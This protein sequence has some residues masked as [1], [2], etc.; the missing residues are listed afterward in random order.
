M[1]KLIASDID[2]T[3]LPKGQKTID[4]DTLRVVSEILDNGIE[5][6]AISGRPRN[7]VMNLFAPVA[8]RIW[9][10]SDNGTILWE[11][12]RTNKIAQ[13]FEIRRD[14]AESLARALISFP[15]CEV[16]ISTAEGHFLWAK[17]ADLGQQLG[18]F[19]SVAP[20]PVADFS[21]V[22]GAITKVSAYCYDLASPHIKDF[23]ET[24]GK[25]F[26]VAQAD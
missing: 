19:F 3:L 17:N 20:K 6:C 13:L 24:W 26:H 22:T 1:V 8:D 12:G 25:T 21:E 16:T 15:Y 5:F 23:T 14:C 11:K 2:G 7:S 4:E 18:K 10:I 9:V